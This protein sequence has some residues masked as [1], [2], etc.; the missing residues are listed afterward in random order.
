MQELR[1]LRLRIDAALRYFERKD[2]RKRVQE[3]REKKHLVGKSPARKAPPLFEF[4]GRNRFRFAS[5]V[6]AKVRSGGEMVRVF[7]IVVAFGLVALSSYLVF[8][9]SYFRISPSKVI[10][11]RLDA[12]SDVN[13]AYKSIEDFYG[14][15]IFRTDTKDVSRAVIAMQK[16][17]RKA[18]V[19][20]LY[21]NGLKIVLSSWGPEFVTYFPQYERYYGVTS[22]G[23]LVYAKNRDPNLPVLDIVDPELAEA[24]FLDYREGVSE[25]A[26]RRIALIR[27]GIKEALPGIVPAKFTFFRL[28]QEVHVALDNGSRI[29]FSLDG[30]EPRQVSTLA[31]W[32]SQEAGILAKN[33]V[34]YVDVRVGAKIY[35]CRDENLCKSNLS[36][37]YGSYYGK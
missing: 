31:F 16:N 9:S 23:V 30:T 11:E 17:I 8:V 25:E 27:N 22:N 35:V 7:S 5:T 28:E 21:P 18:E 37:I 6:Y 3:E 10:I 36:R 34:P 15:P 13:I 20:R 32:N 26:M 14:A 1:R 24:G 29:I 33:T 12:G 4:K 19:S 2:F